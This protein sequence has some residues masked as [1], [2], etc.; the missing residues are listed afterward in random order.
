MPGRRV[1]WHVLDSDLSF[2]KDR[3]E[4]T[5]TTIAFDIFHTGSQTEVTFTHIGLKPE[6]ECYDVCRDGWRT[7]IQGSL[8]QLIETGTGALPALADAG[9]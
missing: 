4:W 2:L 9:A 3:N 7:L 5:G 8:K 6:V 1:G